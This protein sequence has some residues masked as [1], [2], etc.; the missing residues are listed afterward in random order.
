[1]LDDDPVQLPETGRRERMVTKETLLVVEDNPELRSWLSSQLGQNYRVLQAENGREGLELAKNESPELIICDIMMPEMDGLEL[2]RLL[3]GE[4][5][6]SHIPIILLTAKSLEE[7]KIEG[8][9]TGADDYITKPF[10][11]LYLQKRIEN[12][13]Q[14][15]K[16]L[17]ERFKRDLNAEPIDLAKSAAD[18]EFLAKVVELVEENMEDP[19]FSIDSL[20]EHFSF[21]RTVFYKKMKGISGYSPKDFVRILRMKKAGTLLL[22]S[23]ASVAE[24]AFQ[25]G[26][27]EPDYF[28]KLFKKYF[29]ETPSDYQRR[30]R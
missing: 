28:S 1:M 13:L 24:V 8:I 27:N 22:K 9:E 21:G 29:G 7:H 5:H 26:Y 23:D 6:T 12:I 30:C 3:K 10:N 19:E 20:L 15:R 25:V 18:Q 16:Q 4:F 11:M 17:K 2:T 14:Q